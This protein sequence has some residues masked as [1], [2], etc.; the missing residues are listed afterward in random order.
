MVNHYA[1]VG[2]SVME[3]NP[4]IK[5][6]PNGVKLILPS[7]CGHSLSKNGLYQKIYANKKISERFASRGNVIQNIK[8]YWGNRFPN[9][10]NAYKITKKGM[11]RS[12][13]NPSN[14]YPN[15]VVHLAPSIF[16][17]G[18]PP[19]HSGVFKVPFNIM[20]SRVLSNNSL[21]YTQKGRFMLSNLLNYIKAKS[22]NK[23]IVVYGHFC[24]T[25]PKFNKE[26]F[27][28]RMY[29]ITVGDKK[30][31]LPKEQIRKIA[32]SRLPRGPHSP[33]TLKA[34]RTEYLKYKT[35]KKTLPKGVRVR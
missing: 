35:R 15:Q 27:R 26:N 5:Q 21:L 32:G 29:E 19:F 8:N 1:I 18:R 17:E 10:N 30:Y 24:R 23:N 22:N 3:N 34:L 31:R 13:F 2:H 11:G 14:Q 20:S 28:N 4:E 16:K 12:E 9:L 33:K 25:F 6:V 7:K